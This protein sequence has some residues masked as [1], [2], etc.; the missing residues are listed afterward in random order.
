MSSSHPAG[1]LQGARS[2]RTNGDVGHLPY[3][4]LDF[5]FGK[6]KIKARAYVVSILSSAFDNDDAP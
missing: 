5:T 6:K 4:H 1:V 3:F 2:I